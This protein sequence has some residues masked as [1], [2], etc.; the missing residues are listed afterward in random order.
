[1]S[2]AIATATSIT[3]AWHLY[4]VLLD[5]G[6]DR[7]AFRARLRGAGVQTSVHYP[8]LHLTRA[9]ARYSDRPLPMTE[10]YARRAVTVPLFPH[11]TERQQAHVLA[12]I[13]AALTA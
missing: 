13:A 10:E 1:M 7:G 2:A 6:I 9:F 11:M 5:Q 3:N 12:T 4:P 8:P